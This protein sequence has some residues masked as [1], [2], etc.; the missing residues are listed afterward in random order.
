[1]IDF[2]V[3]KFLTFPKNNLSCSRLS[4]FSSSLF[5]FFIFL[6]LV[7]FPLRLPLTFPLSLRPPHIHHPLHIIHP[8]VCRCPD[9]ECVVKSAAAADCASRW[10]KL[11]RKCKFYAAARFP[12]PP[13][14]CC[15]VRC[16]FFLFFPFFFWVLIF[17]DS[18]MCPVPLESLIIL[19]CLGKDWDF[20]FEVPH[21]WIFFPFLNF[22][23]SGCNSYEH[24]VPIC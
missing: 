7:P 17:Y 9:A 12:A 6:S 22:E 24:F 11:C 16:T 8:L 3:T 20:G 18:F 23:L 15:I 13:S 5:P 2:S 1:M 10:Q 19:L 4:P 21:V 14:C